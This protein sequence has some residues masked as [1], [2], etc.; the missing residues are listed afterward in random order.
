MQEKNLN[1]MFKSRERAEG[2][3]DFGCALWHNQ[4]FK[5]LNNI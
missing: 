2:E 3:A 1:K 5:E 4:R